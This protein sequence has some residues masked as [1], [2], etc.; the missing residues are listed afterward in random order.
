MATAPLVDCATESPLV[1]FPC[2]QDTPPDTQ[3]AVGPTAAV[4]MTNGSVSMWAHSDQTP[5]GSLISRVSEESF[6]GSI[7][8]A[9][10]GSFVFT[11]P[12]LLYD[13]ASGRWFASGL[14]FDNAS[15]QEFV[16]LIVSQT[17]DP[18]GTWNKF[19]L[20]PK[21][22]VLRD[23]E[24][25]GVSDDKV[26]LSWDEFT[27]ATSPPAGV[28]L[29]IRKSDLLAGTAPASFLFGPDASRPFPLAVR[30]LSPTTTQ[31]VVYNNADPQVTENKGA[32]TLGVME[33]TGTPPNVSMV[34]F[35]PAIQGRAMGPAASQPGGAPGIQTN[36]DRLLS[37]SWQNGTLWVAG[38]AGCTFPPD[39]TDHSC[40]G[41]VQATT[42]ASGVVV[43]QDT[44]LGQPGVDSYFPALTMDPSGDVVVV[45]TESSS[46][47]PA[48]VVTFAEPVGASFGP[49]SVIQA[50]LGHYC[51]SSCLAPGET[52]VRWG[53]Y[54]AAAV[55]PLNPARLFV[56]G[57]YDA[58]ATDQ[59]DWGT[60]PPTPTPTPTPTP[61][62]SPGYWFVASDG[63]IFSFGSAG[64]FGSTEAT[65]L[66]QPIVAM[67]VTPTR[68]GYWL[69][70]RD[71]GIF[72]FGD[73][74]FLGSTGAI[75]LNQPIVAMATT[76]SGR[77][78]WLVAADGGIFGFGDAGFFGSTG[79][80]HLNQPIVG[81]AS[82]PTG[83]GYW[84]VARDGGIFSCTHLNQPIV[85][86]STTPT[87]H[88]YRFVAADG[89]MFTFGDAGFFGSAGGSHLNQPIVGMAAPDAGG[90]WLVA[91]DG[92]IF[93][94]GD[95]G[96]LGST[97]GTHLNRPIVGMTG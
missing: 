69:V 95:A 24:K 60:P 11:D 35:D 10:P 26:A 34:E 65:P 51:N 83:Q 40:L 6:F 87:G 18:T 28:V 58:S 75:H 72:S 78:Y 57:E 73:A 44:A 20:N 68:N 96:F 32:P 59:L 9:A 94:F 84:L 12:N 89:G 76:P 97:G 92:G 22:G 43:T 21:A 2:N 90:Y 37:A 55:D 80:S 63:G 71:G 64:F 91:A 29:V 4:E 41:L 79:G 36:E 39:T 7:F 62:A 19:Q 47:S 85:G 23:Q 53:D 45:A 30:S 66:N 81:M 77:G 5:F 25:I 1:G 13:S 74:P 49:P 38:N 27:S 50:G 52:A 54:S 48:S 31:L 16:L 67:A 88:G 14:V 17:S 61:P 56:A 15:Q 8:G 3:Y 33:F 82:T 93:S 42:S 70:A 46:S 86:V